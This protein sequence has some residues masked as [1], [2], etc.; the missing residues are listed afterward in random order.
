MSDCSIRMFDYSITV[1]RSFLMQLLILIVTISTTIMILVHDMP[2]TT[3]ITEIFIDGYYS[4][5]TV[6]IILKIFYNI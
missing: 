2:N 3:L 1:N 4:D 6:T 5:K